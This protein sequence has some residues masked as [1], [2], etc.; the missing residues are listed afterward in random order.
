M[1]GQ[2]N[3]KNKTMKNKIIKTTN[4]INKRPKIST[5]KANLKYVKRPRPNPYKYAYSPPRSGSYFSVNNRGF[6]VETAEP[7]VT[8]Q[9]RVQNL[10]KINPNLYG[11]YYSDSLGVFGL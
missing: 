11:N 8:Q 5:K 10:L 9:K 2:G 1:S 3:N 4:K 6:S 7:L